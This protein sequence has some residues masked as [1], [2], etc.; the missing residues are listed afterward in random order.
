[1]IKQ[2]VE[3][4]LSPRGWLGWTVSLE[5]EKWATI[6]EQEELPCYY[7][8]G[9]LDTPADKSFLVEKAYFS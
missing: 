5:A 7:L 8:A 4:V 9:K 2:N 3:S 1:L 6:F